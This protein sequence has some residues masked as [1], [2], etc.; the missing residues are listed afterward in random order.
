MN[1]SIIAVTA[2]FAILTLTMV[3]LDAYNAHAK[4]VAIDRRI[5]DINR[6]LDR[7]MN[8]YRDKEKKHD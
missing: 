4:N 5:K 1:K 3:G 8:L 7:I 6:Q 2:A